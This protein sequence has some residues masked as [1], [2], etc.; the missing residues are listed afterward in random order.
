MKN[1]HIRNIRIL[2][3]LV[4]GVLILCLGLFVGDVMQMHESPRVA[5]FPDT[6]PTYAFRITDLERIRQG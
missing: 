2:Y 4:G 3:L 5:Q 1:K 6:D